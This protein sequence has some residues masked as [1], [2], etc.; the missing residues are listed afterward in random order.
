MFQ[1]PIHSDRHA[2]PLRLWDRRLTMTTW[3]EVVTTPPPPLPP[4]R[5]K[6]TTARHCLNSRQ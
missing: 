4:P 2:R 6:A 5:I 1:S 3:R